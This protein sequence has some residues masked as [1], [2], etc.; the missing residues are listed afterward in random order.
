MKSALKIII[1]FFVI[2]NLFGCQQ[3][4]TPKPKIGIVLPLEHKALQE[5]VAGFT[6]KLRE[7]YPEPVQIKVMN[8]QGDMNLQRAI[9]QQMKD[10]NYSLIVPVATGVTQM[11]VSMI[12]NI[13]IVSLAAQFSEQD[14]RKLNPCNIAVVHDE[15]TPEQSIAFIHAAYPNLRHLTLIHSTSDK[16]FSQVKESV[17][18][19]KNLGI[20]IKPLMVAALPELV[21][22]SR[23]IPSETQGIFVLKDNL[24][25]SG[26]PTLA[27]MAHEKQ[28]PLFTSDEGSVETG[29]G[30]AL[31]VRE[32]QIGEEGAKL[33]VAALKKEPMCKLPIVEM[34]QLTVFINKTA[35]AQ[36]K[37]NASPIEV[38]AKNSHYDVAFTEGT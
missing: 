19:G 16:I 32:R 34:K 30:F 6:E 14:R 11:T 35:L 25:V 24:I 18:A 22:A 38:A 13:P 1:V 5:I 15:I 9:I 28:I 10:Q 8:A 17:Q 3:Q 33:A 2:L 4:E 31:G 12:Y 36:Q 21:S 27:K 7:I 20:E 26:M 37:Q 29:A 23:A